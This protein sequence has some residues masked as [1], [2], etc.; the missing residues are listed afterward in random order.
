MNR[1][2]RRYF[3]TNGFKIEKNAFRKIHRNLK[4]IEFL[5]KCTQFKVIPKFARVGKYAERSF[6][7]KEIESAQNKKVKE[8]LQNQRIYLLNSENNF[9]ILCSNIRPLFKTIYDYDVKI[10]FIKAEVVK[11]EGYADRKR[12]Q[13]LDR[14][15]LEKRLDFNRAQVHNFT[16]IPIPPEVQELLEMGKNFAVGGNA[17]GSN[18]YVAIQDIFIKFQDYCRSQAISETIIGNIKAHSILIAEDLEATSTYDH[19]VGQLLRFLRENPEICIINVDKSIDVAIMFRSEYNTKLS[20]IF[21]NNKNFEKIPNYNIEKDLKAFRDMLKKHLGQ[22]VSSKTLTYLEPNSTTSISYG[23]IKLH[24]PEKGLRPITTGY[25]SI[26]CNAQTYLKGFVDPMLSQCTYLVDSPA[27][28]KE[29]LL[30]D[31]PKF[32][33]EKHTIVSYDAVKLFTNVNTNRV[34]SHVLDTIYKS[35][36]LYFKEK[37]E[38]GN[39]YPIPSRSDFRIFMQKVL[40]DFNVCQNNLGYY[41][42]IGGLAMGSKLSGALSN[43]FIHLM[44]ETV[45]SKLIK[46]KTIIHWQRF[47]DDVLC[48]CEKDSVDLILNKINA[49]DKIL[50]V[51]KL[52]NNVI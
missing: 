17:R 44:E 46:N 12:S 30:A 47:A 38:K 3:E 23:M 45:V 4:N 31:L 43:L 22:S 37:D 24:K 36:D 11:N 49:L 20:L 7:K 5:E 52:Q 51:E 10:N 13:K 48:I 40:K 6:N 29:R 15:I 26:T 25:N 2:Q 32:D 8:A 39:R 9:N 50:K 27:K 21:D 1:T 19:R 14:L 41:R 34:V 35:P 18:N 33:P 28:F 16:Q 42:Q